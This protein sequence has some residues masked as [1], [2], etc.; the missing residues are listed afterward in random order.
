MSKRTRYQSGNEAKRR[1]ASIARKVERRRRVKAAANFTN[2]DAF[3]YAMHPRILP[4]FVEVPWLRPWRVNDDELFKWDPPKFKLPPLPVPRRATTKVCGVD[5][6]ISQWLPPGW[7][8]KVEGIGMVA[9]SVE[10]AQAVLGR[11]VW[12][13]PPSWMNDDGSVVEIPGGGT[14]R[15]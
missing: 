3:R 7:F 2:P 14:E 6:V 11:I 10:A 13:S 12:T 9:H 5:V 4:R 1:R 15:R 8:G